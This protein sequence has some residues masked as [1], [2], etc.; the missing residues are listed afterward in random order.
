[1][2]AHGRGENRTEP[3]EAD[4]PDPGDRRRR[5]DTE[6]IIRVTADGNHLTDGTPLGDHAVAK[7]LPDAFVSLLFHDAE[8]RPIDAA[9]RRRFPTRPIPAHALV[10][11]Y[12][13][14]TR[15]PAAHRPERAVVVEALRARFP[16]EA[17]L[18]PSASTRVGIIERFD[19]AD[20]EGGAC[21]DAVVA[22]TCIDNDEALLTCDERAARTYAALGI[23]YEL[24]ADPPRATTDA[25]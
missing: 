22:L 2:R 10:E 20:V 3:T 14:L 7:L 5:I 12:S 23:D 4:R 24:I 15:L 18:V 1:M 19:T 9:P 17:V 11:T 21:N 25:G 6:L 8:R 16:V 13:V